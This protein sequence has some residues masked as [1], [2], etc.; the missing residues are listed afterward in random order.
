MA[1]IGVCLG[2][3]MIWLH[4]NRELQRLDAVRKRT[5][6]TITYRCSDRWVSADFDP[7]TV[8]PPVLNL[9]ARHHPGRPMTWSVQK[10]GSQEIQASTFED[11]THSYGGSLGLR[12]RGTDGVWMAATLSLSD[13]VGEYGPATMW[14]HISPAADAHR[15]SDV[16]VG[17]GPAGALICGPD[18]TSFKE[19]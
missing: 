4:K 6:G 19:A 5:T 1:V 12:W 11:N 2:G 13:I 8:G 18:P 3:G 16:S 17:P 10:P 7:K 14:V 9:I 15:G